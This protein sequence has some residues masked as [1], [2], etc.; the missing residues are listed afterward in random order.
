MTLSRRTLLL[1]APAAAI[2]GGCALSSPRPTVNV[3]DYGAVGDG[4]TDDSGA[5]IAATAALKPGHTLYF[6]TGSYR[7]AEKMPPMQA[8]I[9]I[10]GLSDVAVEFGPKAELLMD[11]LDAGLGRGHGVLV[12]G[13]ASGVTLRNVRV[14][15]A[16]QPVQR[17]FGDGIRILG[18]PSD[19]TPPLPDWTGST[20]PVTDV[21]LFDCEVESSPQAG[22]IMMGVAGI[23]VDGL[24]VRNSMADGLHFNACRRATVH[25]HRA[26]NTGDDGLALVTYYSETFSY[27]SKAQ[28]FAFPELNAWSDS[29][30]VISNVTVTGGGANGLRLAGANDVRIRWLTVSGKRSGAGV[31]ADSAAP[32]VPAGWHYL[33]ARGTRLDRVRIADCES[34]I[35]LLARPNDAVDPRFTDFG[36]EA[37]TVEIRGCATWAVRAE[38]MTAQPATGLRLDGCR[39]ESTSV[40]GG[41]GGVGL[42]NVHGVRLG[43]VSVRHPGPV[44]VIS[45]YRSTDLAADR[46]AVSVTD[47]ADPD[48][49]PAPSVALLDSDGRIGEIDVRWPQAPDTWQPIRIAGAD[50]QCPQSGGAPAVAVTKVSVDPGTV[51]EPVGRC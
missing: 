40:T 33:A 49:A 26:V 22:V 39:I 9:A 32:G 24:T 7:F 6:P 41:N 10:C 36:L 38:S 23:R 31:I 5:V 51:A 37:G 47:S 19:T 45:A 4:R 25:R 11:N 50:G 3:R 42:E 13:R 30:F 46:L 35:H 20:G 43:T 34:G 1:A 48:T 28:T 15:W 2:L 44:T 8:A 27:N 12:C 18:Y 16:A 21:K 17:S 14:R 29:G